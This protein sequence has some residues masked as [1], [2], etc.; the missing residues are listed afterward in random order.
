MPVRPLR[1]T[2][3]LVPS[4]V[5]VL[6]LL[7]MLTTAAAVAVAP[8]PLSVKMFMVRVA[9]TFVMMA[10]VPFARAVVVSAKNLSSLPVPLTNWT[11]DQLPA[12]V[13]S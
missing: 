6:L 7:A 3:G 2:V 13:Q 5:Q 12:V 8:K 1:F 10:F 4:I 9:G 11:E